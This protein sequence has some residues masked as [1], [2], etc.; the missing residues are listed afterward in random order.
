M[1]PHMLITGLRACLSACNV[2][3]AVYG[4]SYM[5]F[6]CAKKQLRSRET[7]LANL[8]VKS[9]HWNLRNRNG[10]LYQ[11]FKEIRMVW[12]G[13]DDGVT[14]NAFLIHFKR[15]Q[16]LLMSPPFGAVALSDTF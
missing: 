5:E 1:S 14:F 6:P 16:N 10:P 11:G 3:E 12:D 2:A 7:L 4:T 13:R 9:I 8:V 15:S